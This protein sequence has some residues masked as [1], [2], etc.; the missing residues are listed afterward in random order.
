MRVASRI[1][2]TRAGAG[3]NAYEPDRLRDRAEAGFTEFPRIAGFQGRGQK[4][5]VSSRCGVVESRI[6]AAD[7][8]E[9][10]GAIDNLNL[11]ASSLPDS[12]PVPQE[13][14]HVKIRRQWACNPALHGPL[15]AAFPSRPSPGSLLVPFLHSSLQPHLDQVH[16]M[17]VEDS[18]SHAFTPF[19]VRDPIKILGQFRVHDIGI[20]FTDQFMYLPDRVLRAPLR[21][22]AIRTWLQIRLKDWL[23]RQLERGLRRAVP[24][25]RYPQ[26]PFPAAGLRDHL[27][28]HRLVNLVVESAAPGSNSVL[29]D[30]SS[31]TCPLLLRKHA[32]KSGPIPPPALACFDGTMACPQPTLATTPIEPC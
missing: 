13:S 11:Q 30:S 20:A 25:G 21:T 27:P 9:I 29:P 3:P 2:A 18:P 1:F 15:P 22:V 23:H 17:Q 6:G 31:I 14:V 8:H 32:N 24:Y 4:F 28:P 16:H 7:N 26:W 5:G 19:R 12:P 10:I